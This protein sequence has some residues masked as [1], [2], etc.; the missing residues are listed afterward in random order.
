MKRSRSSF[1]CGLAVL[2]VVF[3]AVAPGEGARKFKERP[4]KGQ[5]GMLFV[6]EESVPAHGLVVK[7]SRKAT[8][9]T[10]AQTGLA[11]PFK[12]VQ[13][14]GSKSITLSNSPV[15]IEPDGEFRLIFRS[16]KSG[17][18]IRGWWWIDERGRRVGK[19]K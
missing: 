4:Q 16:Y 2:A 5:A 10:D 17:L 11:G 13:G 15:P 1:V 8:V 18:T 3:I 7:L 14:N 19:K 12:N 9:V 6:N